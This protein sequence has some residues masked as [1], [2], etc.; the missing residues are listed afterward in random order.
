M[1]FPHLGATGGESHPTNK[2]PAGASHGAAEWLSQLA[3]TDRACCC[4]AKPVVIAVMPQT[5]QRPHP[6]ELLLCGHH[7]HVSKEALETAGA[8]TYDSRETFAEASEETAE[9]ASVL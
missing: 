9:P 8:V 4:T 7:H 3:S 2:H 5:A 1:R 6:I